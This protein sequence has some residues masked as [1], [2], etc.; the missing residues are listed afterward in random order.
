MSANHQILL[1][2]RPHGMPVAENFEHVE[3][4]APQPGPGELQLR[5]IYLSVDPYLRGR[6]MDAKSYIAPF[7]IG[8]PV[9]SGCVAE[10]TA[11]N[12]DGFAVGD[13]VVGMMDWAEVQTHS[14]KDLT[15]MS[16][17]A[18]PLSYALGVLG[19]PG[20]TAW[21]GL[22]IHGRPKE[23]ETLVVSAASGAVGSLVTQLGKARGLRVVGV[24]GGAEKCRYVVEELG[25]D[26]CLDHR[27]PDLAKK[28]KEACPKG[29]DIYFENVAGVTLEAVIPL[30]N[31]FSRIPLCGMIA[32]YNLTAAPEGP[33]KLPALWRKLLTMRVNV[34]GFIVFDH[35]DRYGDFLAEVG[36]MVASG[37][38]KAKET[39]SHG[40]AEA[41]NAFISLL[42]GG[43][44]GKAVVKVGDEPN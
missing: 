13:I 32:N 12:N 14:G 33:D 9:Q 36:P 29:I 5:L 26:I 16:K 20:M 4:T 34:R 17:T 22:N 21:A 39:V 7:E 19:M 35:W 37:Q 15:K 24:A 2:S 28:M 41:P 27:D 25:A 30:L 43:N 11:S 31:P 6:M 42:Q 8:K 38:V 10:V 23:G 44:F 3:A 1:A 40:L 18:G